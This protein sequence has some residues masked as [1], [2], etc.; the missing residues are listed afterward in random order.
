MFIFIETVVYL[1]F[2]YYNVENFSNKDVPFYLKML[3]FLCWSL[4]FNIIILLPLD[5]YY[6]QNINK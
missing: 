6:V 2:V 1:G 5:I 4:S 3:V